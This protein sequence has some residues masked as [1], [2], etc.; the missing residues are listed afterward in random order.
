MSQ[1]IINESFYTKT[2][3]KGVVEAMR[4]SVL[5]VL[6]DIRGECV[7]E[8]PV[9]TGHL[10][11]HH[12]IESKNSNNS[13]H[14]MI[15]VGEAEYWKD[16]QYGNRYRGANPYITRALQNAEPLPSAAQYFEQYLKNDKV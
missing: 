15:K 4:K 14:G 12:F 5:E 1:T 16:V 2:D 6:E 8:V 11:A 13:I 10:Q 9:D 3:A 7:A